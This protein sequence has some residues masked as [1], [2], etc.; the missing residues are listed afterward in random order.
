MTGTKSIAVIVVA[1]GRGERAS[2]SGD[3]SPK[4]YRDLAGTP[5]LSRSI[6]AFL[7][8]DDVK[9]GRLRCWRG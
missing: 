8:R 9:R 5:V 3:T 7:G 1:A 4:Q 2:S 6:A